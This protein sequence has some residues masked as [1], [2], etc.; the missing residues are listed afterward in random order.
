MALATL[1]ASRADRAIPPLQ[2]AAAI[3]PTHTPT[4]EALARLYIT[5]ASA[6]AALGQTGSA[7]ATN[8]ERTARE[9]VD[10]HPSATNLS[11]LASILTAR[12]ELDP[13]PTH[14]MAAADALTRA[15]KRDPYGLAFPVRLVRTYT[16]L[17][18][19]GQARRWAEIALERDRLQRLDPL[20]G[21]TDEERRLVEQA[22]NTP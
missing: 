15:A 7:A 19:S 2:T 9:L 14:L 22:L 21:L 6:Q 5:I 16:A 1:A 17:G 3:A 18:D 10:R 11:L 4:V 12:S 8:A 20:R 13:N